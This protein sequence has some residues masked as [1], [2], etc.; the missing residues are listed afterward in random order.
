MIASVTQNAVFGHSLCIVMNG[1]DD[2]D[3]DESGQL[4]GCANIEPSV[5]AEEE[6]EIRFPKNANNSENIIRC[7]L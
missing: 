5:V 3:D 1:D 2:D 6:I 4:L 7:I